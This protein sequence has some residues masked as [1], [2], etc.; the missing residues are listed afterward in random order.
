MLRQAKSKPNLDMKDYICEP[1][2]TAISADGIILKYMFDS[3]LL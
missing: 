1:F 3:I 2:H